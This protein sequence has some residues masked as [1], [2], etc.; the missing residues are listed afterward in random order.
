MPAQ[1][2]LRLHDPKMLPPAL[3]PEAAK[4]DPKDPIRCP[5]AGM[6]VGA[7]GDLKLMAED[8]VLKR[9]ISARSNDSDERPQHEEQ[10]F[11]HPSK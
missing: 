5:E 7:Q 4:P 3:R 9:E 6:R 10:E 8:Q 1:D 2:R 11:E